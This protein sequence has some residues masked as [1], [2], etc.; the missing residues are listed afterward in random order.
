MKNRNGTESAAN[1][2]APHQGITVGELAKRT[3][4]TVRNIRAHQSRGLLDPPRVVGRTGYYDEEHVDRLRLILELQSEGF[5]LEAIR[6]VIE[7]AGESSGELLR[8]TRDV[9]APY[10]TEQSEI[11]TEAEIAGPWGETRLGAEV[12]QR[13]QD[14][15]VMRP[16]GDG[17]FEV[18]SPKLLQAGAEMA[19]LG[20]PVEVA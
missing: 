3:G 17:R 12:M 1:G 4:V 16:L 15:G 7:S 10:E 2:E 9:R 19:E 5:N 8:F 11:L 18:I 14:L 20:I 6:R 13:V